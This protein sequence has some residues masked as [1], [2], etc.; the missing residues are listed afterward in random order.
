MHKELKV[1]LTSTHENQVIAAAAQPT[2]ELRTRRTAAKAQDRVD[3]EMSV[4]GTQKKKKQ[5]AK[6]AAAEPLQRAHATAPS[7]SPAPE[8]ISEPTGDPRDP[9]FYRKVHG[10]RQPRL[11]HGMDIYSQFQLGYH[12]RTKA[13]PLLILEVRL[14]SIRAEGTAGRVVHEALKPYFVDESHGNLVYREVVF[15]M[16]DSSDVAA[17]IEV[18][19]D[20]VSLLNL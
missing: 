4:R 16:N 11:E 18:M 1:Q 20:A 6:K 10:V 19:A 3:V 2:R 14:Q 12:A 17:H 15:N 8:P 5:K 13:A 9:A 7:F